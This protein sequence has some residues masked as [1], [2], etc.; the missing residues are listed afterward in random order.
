MKMAEESESRIEKGKALSPID[1]QIITF[2]DN[3]LV[4]GQHSAAGS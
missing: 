2:K 1:G 3:Y 4:K